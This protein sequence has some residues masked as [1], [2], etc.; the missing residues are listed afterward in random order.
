MHREILTPAQIKLLPVVKAFSRDFGLVG[1]T[2][3][4]LYLGHRESLDFDLFT[5][6]RFDT[7]KIRKRIVKL[8]KIDRVMVDE[9]DQ[10]SAIVGG[11]K[12]SF[13]RYPFK[14][15]FAKKMDETIRLPDLLTLAAMKA[16]ALGRRAK[17]KDYVDLFF[18]GRKYDGM[19]KVAG[20]AKRI[21]GAEFNE[22]VFRAGL[23]YF[24]DI[25]YSEEVIYTKGFEEN[26]KTI[27]KELIDFSL[28]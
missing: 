9:S 26:N 14:I 13:L 27:K 20:K 11:V 19:G 16:Y 12:C 23:S 18:I 8:K 21:F 17:W 1:G 25:D 4:A 7:S 15:T 3:V 28:R 5:N 24:R 10:F 22:K 6:G 2:A